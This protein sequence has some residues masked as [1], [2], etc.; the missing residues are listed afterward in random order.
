MVAGRPNI[1]GRSGSINLIITDLRLFL[2]EFSS[3]NKCSLDFLFL[4]F[5]VWSILLLEYILSNSLEQSDYS[6]RTDIEIVLENGSILLFLTFYI[7]KLLNVLVQASCF[8]IV[9]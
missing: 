3:F 6:T 4:S 5:N 7:P 9:L 1:G 2:D 8:S